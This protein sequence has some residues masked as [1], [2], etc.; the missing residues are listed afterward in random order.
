MSYNQHYWPL[1][2]CPVK[3]HNDQIIKFCIKIIF[4]IILKIIFVFSDDVS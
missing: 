1:T 2:F 3:M 4:H